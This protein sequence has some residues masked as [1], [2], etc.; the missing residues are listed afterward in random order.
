MELGKY[1]NR[2]LWANPADGHPG[3]LVTEVYAKHVFSY[4]NEEILKT[5]RN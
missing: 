4:L 5:K 2:A 3:N 1:Q